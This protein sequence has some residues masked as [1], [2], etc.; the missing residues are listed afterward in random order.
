MPASAAVH[1]SPKSPPSGVVAAPP[2]RGRTAGVLCIALGIFVIVTTEILPIGLLPSMAAGFGVSDGTAG[3]LVTLPG[4]LAAVSAPGVAI[5]VGRADRRLVLVALVALLAVVNVL[6]AC[7]PWFWLAIVARALLGV[8]IGGF[9]SIGAA[10]A[11][12]LVPAERVPAATAMIFAAVPVGSVLGVPLGTQLGE[13]AGWRV[14]FAV[15]AGLAGVTA[16]IVA[17]SLPALPGREAVRLRVLA[18]HLRH[19]RGIRTAV[20]V[21]ALIV[22]AHFAAYT[23]V[24]PFLRDAAHVGGR[25]VSMYLLVYGVAGIAGTFLAGRAIPRSAR[26]TFM[27]AAFLIAGTVALLPLFGRLHSAA[28]L[29]LLVVWGVAYG[30][31]PACSQA[32][33]LR[34]APEAP[35]A[36]TVLFTSSFQLTLAAGALLGGI[37]VD[38][39]SPSTLMATAA[40]PAALA[41]VFAWAARRDG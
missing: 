30:A 38:A 20:W 34:G 23:Y 12:R 6:T 19:S 4:L 17:L 16:V 36:V 18:G 14:V 13:H 9:W 21:T 8:V 37:M 7:A 1:D 32:Y 39:T 25:W 2:P 33:F 26:A 24:T 3:L 41:G 11:P 28:A 29:G 40:V 5:V 27:S 31:V 15:L 10:L 35:E 22:V